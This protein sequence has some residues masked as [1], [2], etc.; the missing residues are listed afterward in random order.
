MLEE[1]NCLDFRQHKNQTLYEWHRV[2]TWVSSLDGFS[3]FY[4]RSFAMQP[5]RKTTWN[6]AF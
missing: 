2:N 1:H 4:Q 6:I 3:T 5:F